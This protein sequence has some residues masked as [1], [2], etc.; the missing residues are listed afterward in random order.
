M[1]IDRDTFVELMSGV[2]S[3]VTVITATGADRR[4]HGSTVS[5]FASLSLDPPLA[6]L[7]LGRAS[8]LLPHL[9]PGDRIGVNILGVHQQELA[10]VFARR[11]QEGSKFDGVTWTFR[12]GLP[13]LPESA[14]WTAGIVERHVNGGDHILIVV[15]LEEAET[16]P[17][18]PLT[19]ARRAFGTHTPLTAAS[20]PASARIPT[21]K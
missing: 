4:P 6:S 12:A 11:S 9:Q 10:S 8:G 14:G 16:S 15:R 13:H 1:M 17:T 20:R 5:S 3:P 21:S 7:A 2:C 18:P 19:Y